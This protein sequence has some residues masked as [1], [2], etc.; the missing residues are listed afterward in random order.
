M[1]EAQICVFNCI[2]GTNWLQTGQRQ[3]ADG[4]TNFTHTDNGATLFQTRAGPG[5]AHRAH[6][7]KS[8]PCCSFHTGYGRSGPGFDATRARPRTDACLGQLHAGNGATWGLQ[9]DGGWGL[10][11]SGPF[12]VSFHVPLRADSAAL[13][14]VLLFAEQRLQQTQLGFLGFVLAVFLRHRTAVL[15]LTR[16]ERATHGENEQ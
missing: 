12:V 5:R 14:P 1:S 8:C 11:H 4:T 3:T 13:G 10:I 2:W 6:M 7:H 9:K 15:L 16:P